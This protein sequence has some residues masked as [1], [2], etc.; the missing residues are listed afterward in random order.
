M[1]AP[2]HVIGEG[3]ALGEGA[4]NPAEQAQRHLD[5]P[6]L[7]T[8]GDAK[9]GGAYVAVHG[10]I[11]R[12]L[13]Q[14]PY[15]N[16]PGRDGRTGAQCGDWHVRRNL[17]YIFRG[18]EAERNVILKTAVVRKFRSIENSGTVRFEPDVTCLV[19]K[20]ESGKTAF[21]EA[22][23]QAN[24]FAGTGRGFDELRDYP[25]RLRGR[26]R[27]QIAGTSPISATFELDDADLEAVARQVG[28]DALG[29]KEL[30]V[31]RAYSG[32]RRLLVGDDEVEGELAAV[33]AA[34]LPRLLYFDGYSV[35]PGRVSIP[36]LQATAEDA[37]QPGERTA[38]ALL[39]LAGVAADEF[40]ES[41]YEV[42]KAA[43]ES[44][45][46][47]VSEEV[48]RYWSQNPEL[49]VELDLD[50]RETGQ[51]GQGGPPFLDVRIRNQRHRVTTN[52]GER[53]GGFVWFFSFVAAFSE[54]RDAESLVLLLDEPGLG[55]HAAGQADL[56]RY[57][58]EQLAG[59]HPGEHQVVYTTHSPFMVDATR[60]H[61]VRTVED[62]EG[63]GTRV[64]Q[65]AGPTSRDTVLPLSGALAV[66]LLE[67]L[68]AGPRTLLVGGV[69]DLVYL[70]VMSG[71]LREG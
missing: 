49:T 52:F 48:F 36:R 60:P 10:R 71:Y 63:E 22:L 4:A 68:G 70:E 2:P 33:L 17:H 65:G 53:S 62:V 32:H 57:L 69:P 1:A 54:L 23:H 34:R 58:D 24:P 41:D 18:V 35:L 21:L 3:A 16:V 64:G 5:L 46:T 55:L 47:T 8:P 61:R 45:A 38:L 29:D 20:N 13:L 67:G 37:L 9:P 6:Y 40:V 12:S 11:T 27:A 51:N 19:G 26:D 25:R 43:L 56:L 44:A 15:A 42:R 50:F 31:E 30:T 7:A 66:S 59:G 39:R 14:L 28:P